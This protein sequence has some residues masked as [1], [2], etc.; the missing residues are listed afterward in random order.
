MSI[1]KQNYYFKFVNFIVYIR[2]FCSFRSPYLHL[3]CWARQSPQISSF[4]FL[5]SRRASELAWSRLTWI[6]R[7][8]HKSSMSFRCCWHSTQVDLTLALFHWRL[9]IEASRWTRGS[10][11]DF[12]G[13]KLSLGHRGKI[14]EG[15]SPSQRL[16]S[17]R[18]PRREALSIQALPQRASFV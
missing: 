2:C 12:S 6:L 7:S 8:P 1:R 3:Q 15:L 9:R 17:E 18:I 14:L 4:G 13:S 16:L 5:D 11:A 10:Q